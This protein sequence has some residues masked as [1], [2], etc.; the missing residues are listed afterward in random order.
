MIAV[1][2]YSVLFPRFEPTSASDESLC[3][4]FDTLSD[5][6]SRLYSRSCQSVPVHEILPYG[7]TSSSTGKFAVDSSAVTASRLLVLPMELSRKLDRLRFDPVEGDE[8]EE[9]EQFIVGADLT[10]RPNQTCWRMQRGKTTTLDTHTRK[11]GITNNK[12]V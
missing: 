1:Q 7:A 11:R 5:E 12:R 6:W 4:S 3:N 2:I 9:F 10:L 8:D